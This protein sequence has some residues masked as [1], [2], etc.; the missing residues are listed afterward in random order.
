MTEIQ[1]KSILVRVSARFE[2]ARVRVIGSRLYFK[3]LGI[4]KKDQ[5]RSI[6]SQFLAWLTRPCVFCSMSSKDKPHVNGHNIL[7]LDYS[8]HFLML[9]VASV[10]K[11][12]CILLRVV[13]S[14]C[15]KF[16]SGGQTFSYVQTDGTTPNTVWP[17]M[18]EAD[19]VIFHKIMSKSVKCFFNKTNVPVVWIFFGVNCWY[20]CT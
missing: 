16:E 6:H 18:L 8:Q 11:T 17:T 14:C 2:L 10:C 19:E 1:G 7:G 5:N 3:L 4:G 15:A 20:F 13:G 12:F 9:H